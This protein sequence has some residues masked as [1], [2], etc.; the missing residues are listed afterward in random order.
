MHISST[1][2]SRRL[3]LISLGAF[4]AS[5]KVTK[6]KNKASKL[7]VGFLPIA[8]ALP[9]FVAIDQGLFESQGLEIETVRFGTS[10]ELAIAASTG[11]IDVIAIGATNAVLD[12]RTVSGVNLQAFSTVEYIKGGLDRK[13]TDALVV[14]AGVEKTELDGKT[15]AFFPGSVSKVFAQIV[16]EKNGLDLSK[17]KYVEMPPGGWKAAMDSG[18][19]DGVHAVEPFLELFRRDPSYSILIDGYLAEAMSSVPLS[20][21]WFNADR[22]EPEVMNKFKLA[23]S[24]AIKFIETN[25]VEALNS[26]TSFSAMPSDIYSSIGLNRWRLTSEPDAQIEFTN[27]V[28]LLQERG[29][30]KKVAGQ[31]IFE[32]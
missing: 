7:K 12:A 26:F 17:I 20:A 29:A 21:S 13:S 5:C 18:A 16:F 10:N 15:I 6:D 25:R 28:E 30:I 22:T 8:G 3:L 14:K 19:I 32:S 1:T 24:D 23:Y 2:I 11:R 27:F 31:Y 9:L 4:A